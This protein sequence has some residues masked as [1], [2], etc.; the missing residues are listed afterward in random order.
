[1]AH[2]REQVQAGKALA[3]DSRGHMGRKCARSHESIQVSSDEGRNR[4]EEWCKGV[5][6]TLDRDKIR[7]G[8]GVLLARYSGVMAVIHHVARKCEPLSSRSEQLGHQLST[9]ALMWN[10][11][12]LSASSVLETDRLEPSLNFLNCLPCVVQVAT[13]GR[14]LAAAEW[15][16]KLASQVAHSAQMIAE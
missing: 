7:D 8:V 3:R 5:R 9:L 2:P 16:G 11:E 15:R 4:G 10:A 1:M 14:Q 12:A 13:Q 6:I